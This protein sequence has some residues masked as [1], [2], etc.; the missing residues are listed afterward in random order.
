MGLLV[1][2][3]TLADFRSFE[4]RTIPLA[5]SSTLFV[6]PNAAGKTNAVEAL[7]ML[8]AGGS[9]RRPTPS[10]LVREGA[11]RGRISAR[12]EGDGRLVDVRCDVA[13]GRRSFSRNGKRCQAHDMP[14]NL[15]SVLFTPDDL[16]LVKRGASL[17]RD[18][19]DGFGC[20]ANRG[21]SNV[22]AA[23]QRSVEQRNRLLKEDR[24]DPSLLD[25]WD[26]SL[27]LGGATL[28]AARLRLFCRLAD[29][30]SE[31]YRL[32]SG[33]EPLECAYE[34]TLAEGVCA[35]DR[36]SLRDLMLERLLAA[37]AE[38]LRRQQTTVGPHR[39][40]VSFLIDGRPARSF[41]SQ[42]QQRSVVLALKMAEVE[43][44]S[45]ITGSRPLLLLDDVM[46]ELDEDRR[47]AMMALAQKG[48][49]TVVTTTNLGYFSPA[50][51]SGAEVVRFG[52]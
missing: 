9:F 48:V 44:A 28:L 34:S 31:V 8:T 21:Y 16:G 33:G 50:L 40:D 47:E 1:T 7:Q 25:A 26:E 36:D 46:S 39:D 22:L 51:L 4:H 6:G 2:E 17:R 3:L 14:Q 11:E 30:V 18:E 52:G 37:R 35:L 24:P 42:G 10:Q 13:P 20:Q 38:D 5:A 23:Y 43:L 49:Q 41:G 19:L 12:L 15:M 27:A 32:I 29:K 45:E